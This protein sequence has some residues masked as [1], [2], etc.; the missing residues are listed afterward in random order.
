M[1]HALSSLP[2]NLLIHNIDLS[3]TFFCVLTSWYNIQS[4]TFNIL[5][6]DDIAKY[7]LSPPL[8]SYQYCMCLNGDSCP[9]GHY[10]SCE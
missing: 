6:S 8:I 2:F 7:L 4:Q 3:L 10:M 9:L 5:E 1:D